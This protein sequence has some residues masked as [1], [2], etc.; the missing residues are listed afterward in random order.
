MNIDNL[1]SIYEV[2]KLSENLKKELR[3]SWL[4]DNRRESVAEHTWRVSFMAILLEPLIKEEFHGIDYNKVIRMIIVHDIVEAISGDVFLTEQ[5]KDPSIKLI[6]KQKEKEAIKFIT[7]KLK[8]SNGEEILELFLEFEDKKSIEAIIANSM[9]NLEAQIQH[10]QSKIDT[11]EEIEYS[12]TYILNKHTK[13]TLVMDELRKII[14]DD[15]ELKMKEKGLD[16]EDIKI[17]ST[18]L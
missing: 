18:H 9:D 8:S 10:N 11:W 5:I 12:M 7:D 15:A 1:K 13:N 6:K 16:I 17:K 2:I 3:H 14:V 4:S